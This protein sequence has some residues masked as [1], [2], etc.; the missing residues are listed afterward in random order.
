MKI[1][2][3]D[4]TKTEQIILTSLLKKLGHKVICGENGTQAIALYQS[5]NPDLILLDVIMPEMDGHEAAR[6]IRSLSGDWIPI[7]FLSGRVHAADI[8]AG[9]EAGGDDYLTKPVDHTVLTA[10]VHAMQRIAAMRHQL[11]KVTSELEE[12]NTALQRLAHIDSL[13]GLTN[14]RHLDAH[15]TN[16]VAT[17]AKTKQP[18]SVIMI[19][20]DYFKRYND[21][22][23]HPAGDSCLKKIAKVLKRTVTRPCD[24]TARYGGEEFSVILP[25]TPLNGAK[26]VAETIRSN[27]EKLSIPHTGSPDFNKVT[28][29][30]GVASLVPEPDCENHHL[31]HKA[32]KALYEAKENGR[33]QVSCG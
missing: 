29:S 31:L 27:I 22:Y 25:D 10:K 32:D 12:A 1:L 3:V 26:H 8:A 19:D 24:M 18:L 20:V 16:M 33:N 17:C 7:I 14:R 9:I 21:T 30:F 2:I 6:R 28:A 15:L 13:T 5:H 23:G 4:D 11:I